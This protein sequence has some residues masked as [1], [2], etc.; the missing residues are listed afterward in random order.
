MTEPD[1]PAAASPGGEP[2]PPARPGAR[3]RFSPRAAFLLSFVAV[4]AIAAVAVALVVGRGGD[5]T[6]PTPST[7]PRPSATRLERLIAAPHVVFRNAEVGRAF[8]RVGVVAL[9]DPEGPRALAPLSCERIDTAG[10]RGICLTA[11]RGSTT[12]YRAEVFDSRFRVTHRFGLSGVPSRARVAPDGRHAA[13][14]VFTSGECYSEESFTT[15]TIIVDL[16]TGKQLGNLD[17]F[18][19]THDGAVVDAVDRNYWGVTF[20]PDSG[21]FYATLATGGKT[22]LIHGDIRSR[23]AE[24]VREG[25]EGPSLSPDGTRIAYQARVTEQGDVGWRIRV[26]DLRTGADHAVAGGH[27]V[28][29]Q[30]EW[31]DDETLLY[32]MPRSATDTAQNDVWRVPADGSGA[33][34]VFIRGA[35]SPAVVH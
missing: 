4:G 6:A 34:E 28:N 5:D 12:R 29:D 14:T 15:R 7:R 30:V 20:A 26:L 32:A 3:R 33:P 19:V 17:Q 35:W 9:D 23:T 18:E 11:D 27:D 24:V 25:I 13:L 16:V 22:Y 1:E 10:G 21:H 8:G 31:L 2:A